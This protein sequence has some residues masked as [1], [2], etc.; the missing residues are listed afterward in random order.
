MDA[1]KIERRAKT[2]AEREAI[3]KEQRENYKKRLRNKKLFNYALLTIVLLA[4]FYVLYVWSQDSVRQG[5]H[6]ALAQCLTSKGV[7]MYGTEWCP[8]CQEQKQLFGASFKFMAYTNC[9]M[10]PDACK[11][12][13]VD[14][15]PTWIFPDGKTA[16][17]TQSLDSLA[18]RTGCG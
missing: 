5:D 8:H 1:Q 13:G 7:M 9:D 18:M 6:D 3:I 2:K 4:I 14:S 15:Y 16:T 17:G 12:A 10:N 11:L